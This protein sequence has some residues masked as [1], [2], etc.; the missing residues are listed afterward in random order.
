MSYD[1]IKLCKI[2]LATLE[3]TG[4]AKLNVHNNIIFRIDQSSNLV[5]FVRTFRLLAFSGTAASANG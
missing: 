3:R 2:K 4:F 5:R 1:G